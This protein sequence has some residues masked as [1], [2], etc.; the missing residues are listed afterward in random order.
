MWTCGRDSWWRGPSAGQPGA[1][2]S[3]LYRLKRAPWSAARTRLCSESL[4]SDRSC[5]GHWP[6]T[7]QRWATRTRHRPC[8]F[9]QQGAFPRQHG[10]RA[11]QPACVLPSNAGRHLATGPSLLVVCVPRAH[12]RLSLGSQQ[13]RGPRGLPLAACVASVRYTASLCLSVCICKMETVRV[14]RGVLVRIKGGSARKSAWREVSPNEVF[15][16][17]AGRR[18]RLALQGRTH[19]TPDTAALWGKAGA[20]RTPHNACHIQPTGPVRYFPTD[21]GN[22]KRAKWDSS[23]TYFK[24]YSGRKGRFDQEESNSQ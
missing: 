9:L 24:C 16:G 17:R 11:G 21:K 13:P 12:S 22:R 1:K 6:T 10:P 3:K 18:G 19:N 5:C 7:A 15:S 14:S 23:I 4:P 2:D 20:P 8:R